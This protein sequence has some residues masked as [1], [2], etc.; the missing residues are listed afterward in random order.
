[1]MARLSKGNVLGP[2]KPGGPSR[3][4][5]ESPWAKANAAKMKKMGIPGR[6]VVKGQV[7]F[8]GVYKSYS[9]VVIKLNG[10]F[11]WSE[12]GTE[13]E[14]KPFPTLQAARDSFEKNMVG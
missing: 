2:E 8:Q 10:K 11:H 13:P 6:G 12:G 5:P 1:M 14:S 7:V 4:D 3:P 9:Y